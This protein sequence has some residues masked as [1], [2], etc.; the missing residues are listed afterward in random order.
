LAPATCAN[1]GDW[2]ADLIDENCE[3]ICEDLDPDCTDEVC[4]N[5]SEDLD[6]II[7]LSRCQRTC[8][9]DGVCPDSSGKIFQRKHRDLP[10]AKVAKSSQSH[11]VMFYD[12]IFMMNILTLNISFFY[13]VA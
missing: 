10:V 8:D 2:A 11:K 7:R 12:E 5:R 13:N 6:N 3:P 9:T 4:S 1:F